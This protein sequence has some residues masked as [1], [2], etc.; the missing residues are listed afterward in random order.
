[1]MIMDNHSFLKSTNSLDCTPAVRQ[2]W[3]ERSDRV[4][5]F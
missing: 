3:L 1:M 2:L 5:G 4:Y